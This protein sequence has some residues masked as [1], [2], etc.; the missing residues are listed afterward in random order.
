MFFDE[1]YYCTAGVL[2]IAPGDLSGF[3][4]C[5]R[6]LA[7]CLLYS[8]TEAGSEEQRRLSFTTLRV[9]QPVAE[10]PGQSG[11]HVL[12]QEENKSAIFLLS[13]SPQ[14]PPPPP[15]GGEGIPGQSWPS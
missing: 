7:R 4:V 8:L 12:Q 5:V 6:D 10:C 2:I 1:G 11:R 9:Q 15:L 3:G 14:P 13:H